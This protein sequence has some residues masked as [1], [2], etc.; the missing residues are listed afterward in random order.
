MKRATLITSIAAA[1]LAGL[2]ASRL[3]LRRYAIA[4]HS[5]A[6]ALLPNDWVLA[7]AVKRLRRG[8][9]VVLPHPD[10][11]GFELVKRVIAVGGQEVAIRNGRIR[12]D[13]VALVEEWDSHTSPD[14]SWNVP[15]DTVFVLGDARRLSVD[16]SR[17]L[18]PLPRPSATWRVAL[19]YWP[20]SRIGV[21]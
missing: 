4:E 21:I 7:M 20:P 18:G 8:D 5:M 16:D 13:G 10:R 2:V 1:T 6:P 19:R 14:G 15:R 12:V 17:M 3:R 9:I 11:H